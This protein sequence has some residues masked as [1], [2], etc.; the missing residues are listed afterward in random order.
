MDFLIQLLTQINAN[1]NS[2]SQIHCQLFNAA[3]Y[4]SDEQISRALT[5]V[6]RTFSVKNNISNQPSVEFL[7]YLAAERQIGKAFDLVGLKS[8]EKNKSLNCL[9]LIIFGEEMIELNHIQSII[10]S[11]Q[12]NA[13][14]FVPRTIDCSLDELIAKKSLFK[15]SDGTLWRIIKCNAEYINS[16]QL[17]SIS[18]LER[19]PRSILIHALEDAINEKMVKMYVE[20]NK[21]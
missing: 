14:N 17:H 21:R 7:L 19:L 1:E 16:T 20:T 2:S 13:F 5:H 3:F 10:T 6:F 4:L 15:I 12:A 9:C 8:P 18:E 11:F